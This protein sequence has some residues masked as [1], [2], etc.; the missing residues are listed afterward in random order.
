[1]GHLL[2]DLLELSR[3]GH[4]TNPPEDV[5][6]AELAQRAVDLLSGVITVR[7]VRITIAPDLPASAP[8]GCGWG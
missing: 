5:A 3:I 6:L 7:G 2:D 8:T 4:I 1:M